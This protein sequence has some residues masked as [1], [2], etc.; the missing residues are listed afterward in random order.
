[1]SADQPLPRS[2]K[3]LRILYVED[4][5]QDMELVL[6]ELKKAGFQC[7]ADRADTEETVL[8]CLNSKSY[9][10]VL[11]DFGLPGWSGLE[12]L[13]LVRAKR[14]DLPFILVTGSL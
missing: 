11:S 9:D 13:K 12:A 4:R 7:E 6:R 14:E 8:Q 10:V 1:M 5:P 3:R 2:S